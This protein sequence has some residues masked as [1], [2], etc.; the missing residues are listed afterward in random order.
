L[1]LAVRVWVRAGVRA[2][3]V[4][5]HKDAAT[6]QPLNLLLQRHC[7]QDQPFGPRPQLA[8]HAQQA[9]HLV[10][11]DSLPEAR[12]NAHIGFERPWS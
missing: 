9:A 2:R 7:F 11:N 1:G 8:R 10:E 5:A 6:L 3:T 12:E 4:H